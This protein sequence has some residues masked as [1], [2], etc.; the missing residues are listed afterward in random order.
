LKRILC[1]PASESSGNL[2]S[3][4]PGIQRIERKSPRSWT[5]SS[6][7]CCPCCWSSDIRKLRWKRGWKI[8]C[9]SFRKV[10]TKRFCYLPEIP[11][12]PRIERKNPCCWCW[13]IL[14]CF[15]SESSGN[16]DSEFPG[17]FGSFEIQSSIRYL[18]IL[19]R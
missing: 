6:M 1:C 19:N 4:F 3:E 8:P 9:K 15:A 14:C 12:I 2:D 5:K 10:R 13:R 17:S 18:R 7:K 11:G 16:L